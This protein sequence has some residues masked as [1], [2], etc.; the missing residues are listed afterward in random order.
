MQK[1]INPLLPILSNKQ[2]E[3]GSVFTPKSILR[4]ARRQKGL[5]E[6]SVS[7]RP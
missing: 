5:N 7:R 4:E 3:A 6:V 1:E 2:H